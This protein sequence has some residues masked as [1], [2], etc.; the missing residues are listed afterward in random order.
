K[1][2]KHNC[3]PKYIRI[4]LDRSFTFGKHLEVIRQK[5]KTRNNLIR[6]NHRN[7][8]ESTS[9]NPVYSGTISEYCTPV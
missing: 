5:L 2:I 1:K 3:H 6:K 8:L 4:I 7:K 9:K